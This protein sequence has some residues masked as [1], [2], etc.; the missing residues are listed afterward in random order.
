VVIAFGVDVTAP[1]AGTLLVVIRMEDS[2]FGDK[3]QLAIADNA[4]FF[5][6]RA[7]SQLC[8]M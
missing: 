6:R 3:R 7:I 4:T 8:H 2:F 5:F 1:M